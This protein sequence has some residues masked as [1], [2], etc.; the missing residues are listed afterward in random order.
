[1]KDIIN[2]NHEGD[3]IEIMDKTPKGK[4]HLILTDPHI[5]HLMVV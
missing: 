3:C 5:M 4:V 1:M 2:K